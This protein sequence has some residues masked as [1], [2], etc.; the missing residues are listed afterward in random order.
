MFLHKIEFLSV[1]HLSRFKLAFLIIDDGKY[2]GHGCSSCPAQDATPWCCAMQIES[3]ESFVAIMNNFRVASCLNL[4]RVNIGAIY[5]FTN[6]G[7]SVR[8][9]CTRAAR[10]AG[11]APVQE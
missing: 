6:A 10:Y 1:C 4:V 7:K 3:M 5:C 8:L 9:P 2:L 11:R